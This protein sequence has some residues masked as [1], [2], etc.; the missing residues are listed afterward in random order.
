MDVIASFAVIGLCGL[1]AFALYLLMRGNPGGGG[2][3]GG[4]G[5]GGETVIVPVMHIEQLD[6]NCEHVVA[7]FKVGTIGEKGL[8]ISRPGAETGDILLSSRVDCAH[9]VSTQHILIGHDEK[10]YFL[11]DNHSKN[12]TFLDGD[13]NPVD[14]LDITDGMIVWL[15]DQPIR[16]VFR[17]KFEK[18]PVQPQPDGGENRH[19]G[20]VLRRKHQH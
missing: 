15:G 16:F 17:K 13:P 8:S 5:G 14:E 20:G 10:G 9:T 18:K 3:T 11:Q 4:G 6:E 12:S 2:G 1:V 7:T 19:S